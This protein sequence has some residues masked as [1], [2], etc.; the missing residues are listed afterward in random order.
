MITVYAIWFGLAPT[1]DTHCLGDAE[2]DLVYKYLA[3]VHQP[4]ARS[5]TPKAHLYV[6]RSGTPI[7]LDVNIRQYPSSRVLFCAESSTVED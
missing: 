2:R 3:V 6:A 7:P 4:L 1:T 5:G